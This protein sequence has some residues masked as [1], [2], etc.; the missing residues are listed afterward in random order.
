MF[1][2]LFKHL[3]MYSHIRL[4]RHLLHATADKLAPQ[5]KVC[6]IPFVHDSGFQGLG[7]SARMHLADKSGDR[8][9]AN[10][11]LQSVIT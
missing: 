6:L 3:S 2:H 1:V 5:I 10:D 11:A 8:L 7:G 9:G 4:G